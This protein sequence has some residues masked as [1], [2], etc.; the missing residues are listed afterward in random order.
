M[1]LETAPTDVSMRGSGDFWFTL[2]EIHEKNAQDEAGL[3]S[4]GDF[5]GGLGASC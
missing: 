5:W 4:N 3:G 1:I 2:K